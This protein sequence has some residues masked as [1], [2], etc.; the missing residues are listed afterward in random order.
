MESPHSDQFQKCTEILKLTEDFSLPIKPLLL[1]HLSK[2][3]KFLLD[4]NSPYLE[5]LASVRFFTLLR[6]FLGCKESELRTTCLKLYRYTCNSENSFSELKNSHV[7]HFIIRSFE[8]EGK[9]PERIEA[10]G[11]IRRWLELAPKNFPK[12]ICNSLIALSESE[13]DDLKTS[14]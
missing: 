2:R 6:N 4:N 1:Q 5:S 12:G 13:G 7:E 10:C 11:L 8:L 14:A 3:I 9:I